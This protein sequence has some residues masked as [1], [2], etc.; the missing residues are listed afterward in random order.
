MS[1]AAKSH[2]LT[3]YSSARRRS[4]R[5]AEGCLRLF[6]IASSESSY[7]AQPWNSTRSVAAAWR[8]WALAGATECRK[9]WLTE[10]FANDGLQDCR[11]HILASDRCNLPRKRNKHW[12]LPWEPD[13]SGSPAYSRQSPLPSRTGT[14]RHPHRT[15]PRRGAVGLSRKW[16]PP[17]MRYNMPLN[18]GATPRPQTHFLMSKPCGMPV[19]SRQNHWSAVLGFLPHSIS[20]ALGTPRDWGSSHRSQGTELATRTAYRTKQERTPPRGLGLLGH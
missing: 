15:R 20:A 18:A 12:H 16:S 19:S 2:T 6:Q 4:Q 13:I 11:A 1:V 9:Q 7:G 10:G 14:P 8:S 5:F 17:A 3:A